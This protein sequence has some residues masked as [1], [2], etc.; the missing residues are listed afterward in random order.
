MAN[1][2]RIEFG[3]NPPAGERGREAI[4][5]R[6]YLADLHGA[7]DVAT[8]AFPSIWVSD[9]LNYSTEWRLECWTVLT[10]IAAR[11]PGAGLG[12]IVMSNT[13]RHP[14]VMAKMA[15]SLQELSGGRFVLGY[16]AGWHE[17]EHDAFGLDLH[18]P[19]ERID[20]MEEAILLMKALWS[21]APANFTGRYYSISN[22]YAAPRPDPAPPIMV[23]GA[24]EKKTLRVVAKHADWWNDVARA[25]EDLRHKLDVLKERCAE[26]GRDYDSIRKTISIPTYIHRSPSTAKEMAR[27]KGDP[28][29]NAVVGDPAAVCEQY[30]ELRSLGFEL[31][32]TFFDDF[33]DLT[34]MKLFIDKVIPE[35]S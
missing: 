35:F 28:G 30:E 9:H 26:A 11:Y 16:G 21:D 14:S 22:A 27:A 17:G 3:Y 7:L 2:P 6:E 4:R 8:R 31:V 20:R 10:W 13:F 24:G 12:T 25:P 1:P 5:P 34:Q 18:R 15:A 32:I 19:A 23:G 33:Q 29:L